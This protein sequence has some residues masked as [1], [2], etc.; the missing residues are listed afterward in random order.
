MISSLAE[1]WKD[2][3]TPAN[4]IGAGSTRRVYRHG[5]YVVKIHMHPMGHQQSI[6]EE[7]LYDYMN[8][9]GLGHL[10]APV[11]LVNEHICIQRYYEPI[12]MVD[13]QTFDLT[14]RDG[15]WVIPEKY[16]Q[17]LQMLDQEFDAFD[18]KDSSNYGLNEKRELVFIDYGMTKKLYE[19]AWVPAAERGDVPQ[20][21]VLP[22]LVCGI[23]KE[24]RLYG[25]K[26]TDKRCL[27][28]GKV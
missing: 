8:E 17:C 4:F 19:Q 25:E 6:R 2:S 12:P 20:I 14:E 9:N 1:N 5:E 23:E 28:C 18:L 3:C 10:F 11:Y 27:E 16:E 7:E 13:H 21:D 15:D 26:D 24:I 22:C